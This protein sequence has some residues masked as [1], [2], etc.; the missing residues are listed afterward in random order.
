M[1]KWVLLLILVGVLSNLLLVKGPFIWDDQFFIV[2]NPNIRH[3]KVIEYF[4]KP[5]WLETGFTM[6]FRGFYRPLVSAS[7]ALDYQI[8]GLNPHGFHL[9]SVI[10]HI[11][12]TVLLFFILI[13]IGLKE[14]E[15]FFTAAIFSSAATMREAVAWISARGDVLSLFFMLL[16]FY[17]VLKRKDIAAIAIFP[18]ALFSKEMAIIFP[19]SLMVYFYYKEESQKRVLPFLGLDIVFLIIRAHFTSAQIFSN[20]S[21]LTLISRTVKA[22]GFYFLQGIF[23]FTGR[24][25]ISPM[26]VYGSWFYYIPA[27]FFAFMLVGFILKRRVKIYLFT[28]MAFVFL[29]PPLASV[30]L[31]IPHTV[32]FRFGYIPGA[33][34]IPIT[35]IGLSSGEVLRKILLPVFLIASIINANI[36]NFYWT[37]ERLYWEKAHLDSPEDPYF[38]IRLAGIYIKNGEPVRAEKLLSRYLKKP[39]SYVPVILHI[40]ALMEE[41]RGNLKKAELLL[42]DAIKMGEELEKW[43]LKTYGELVYDMTSHYVV[44]SR[45]LREEGKIKEA[46]KLLER[47][48]P[49]YGKNPQFREEMGI[50]F[51]LEGKCDKAE[52]F[53]LKWKGVVNEVCKLWHS[54]D[55][56]SKARLFMYRNEFEKARA[57]CNMLKEGK[58]KCLSEV[59]RRRKRIR[60]E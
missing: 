54:S 58:E 25:F 48:F 32:A 60:G 42:K 36:I 47:G 59:E 50:V 10:F 4:L 49:R 8:Y 41:K 38:G 55:P 21:F 26:K 18:L 29:I 1:K 16:S 2:E 14:S 56:Y 22:M 19:L 24:V 11:G 12:S 23:P 43:E 9:T 40:L 15:S 53:A 45:I 17:L 30:S 44:L 28:A 35:V 46:E 6:G 27:L 20:L 37:S 39:N 7:F 33:F 3:V 52:K 31:E 5:H 13:A 57:M 34:L 51:A